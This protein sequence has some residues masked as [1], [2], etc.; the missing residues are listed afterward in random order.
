M[1]DDEMLEEET[2]RPFVV[3]INDEFAAQAAA[4]LRHYRE[5]VENA[6]SDGWEPAAGSPFVADTACNEAVADPVGSARGS[7][8]A[9]L[10][11]IAGL[12]W[13]TALDHVR[14]LEHDITRKPPPV[15]SP[16]VSARAVLESCL[17][18]QYLIEPSISCGLRLARCAGLWRKDVQHS[19]QA[20]RVFGAEQEAEAA[21]LDAYVTQALADAN[22]SERSNAQGRI[23]GY[24]VDGEVSSLDYKITD[25]AKAALPSWV[26][27]PYAILSGAAH[28]RPW[29]TGSTRRGADETDGAL[30]GEAATVMTALMVVMASL[31]MCLAAWQGFFGADLNE[32]FTELEEHRSQAFMY[33]LGLAHAADD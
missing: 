18:L 1:T 17:F 33:L 7:L 4:A 23:T 8:Y 28:G 12:S 6:F 19:T 21:D 27:M 32:T 22:V 10:L 3:P 30:V 11:D 25:R 31:E 26:P 5:L 9:M 13:S 2:V 16:L 15:W 24:E 29:M 20:A 14:A